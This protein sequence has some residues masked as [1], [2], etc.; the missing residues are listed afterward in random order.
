VLARMSGPAFAVWLRNLA[1]I[2]AAIGALGGAL[3]GLLTH[4]PGSEI[5]MVAL[6]WGVAGA[7]IGAS[8]PPAVRSLITVIQAAG[9]ILLTAV[10]WWIAFVVAGP[11]PW[12]DRGH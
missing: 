8:A 3:A 11:A 10:L 6:R 12:G 9:W 4:L 1:L 5:G 7:A 2:G